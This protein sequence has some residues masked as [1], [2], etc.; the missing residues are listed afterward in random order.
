MCNE[1]FKQSTVVIQCTKY[2]VR[3]YLIARHRFYVNHKQ[4]VENPKYCT[5]YKIKV[6]HIYYK[7]RLLY[8]VS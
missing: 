4:K 2:N 7:L 6:Q 5:W 3:L 8:F 1:Y